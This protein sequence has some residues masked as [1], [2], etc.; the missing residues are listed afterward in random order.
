MALF[1]NNSCKKQAFLLLPKLVEKLDDRPADM[2]E[3]KIDVGANNSAESQ[4]IKQKMLAH[5]YHR[6][7]AESQTS[8]QEFMYQFDR[9]RSLRMWRMQFI[10]CEII[11]IRFVAKGS[12]FVFGSS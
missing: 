1:Q 4:A 7:V 9:I 6:A 10:T 12:Q 11:L 5:M 2:I 3:A 8:L